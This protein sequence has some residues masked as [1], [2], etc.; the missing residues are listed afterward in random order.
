MALDRTRMERN[1]Y[2]FDNEPIKMHD[3]EEDDD[4]SWDSIISEA[5]DVQWYEDTAAATAG[6]LTQEEESF[7]KEW[8]SLEQEL[9]KR[10]NRLNELMQGKNERFRDVLRRRELNAATKRRQA[11][12][13]SHANGFS[14]GAPFNTENDSDAITMRQDRNGTRSRW[15]QTAYD[16]IIFEWY[17]TVPAFAGL[18]L[19]SIAMGGFYFIVQSLIQKLVFFLA[20]KTHLT[21]LFTQPLYAYVFIFV[22]G[23]AVTRCSGYLYWWLKDDVHDCLKFDY[24]NRLRLNFPG[25][26]I[27]HAARRNLISRL[28]FYIIGYNICFQMAEHMY[29]LVSQR[30]FESPVHAL[31]NLPSKVI[32][33]DPYRNDPTFVCDRSCDA[34]RQSR[35]TFAAALLEDDFTFTQTYVSPTAHG[36]HWAKWIEAMDSLSYDEVEVTEQS[37]ATCVLVSMAFTVLCVASLRWYGFVFWKTV[38]V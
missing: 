37:W 23:A 29:A 30:Y 1:A 7:L 8:D 31:R 36:N 13:K 27:L 20:R 38:T 34:E 28:L 24:H 35:Q 5:R 16:F 11:F 33:Y 15:Q 10:M 21:F 18:F 25:A 2:S 4:C 6:A 22:V 9:E 3:D 17:T 19:H 32:T 12:V 26:R 14:S